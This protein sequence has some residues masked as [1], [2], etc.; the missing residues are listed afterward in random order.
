MAEHSSLTIYYRKYGLL[1]II[2]HAV[3]VA[4]LF[5][6]GAIGV[7]GTY[8]YLHEFDKRSQ[9]TIEHAQK[10]LDE[11]KKLPSD[12]RQGKSIDDRLVEVAGADKPTDDPLSP[13]ENFWQHMGY[14]YLASSVA[15]AKSNARCDRRTNTKW[16]RRV[17][18]YTPVLCDAVDTVR[19]FRYGG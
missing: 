18:R 10:K 13:V 19:Y 1:P 7:K 5:V 12:I 15:R 16:K 2:P 14:A 6:A 9:Q 4:N 17:W 3:M 8:Q 11:I